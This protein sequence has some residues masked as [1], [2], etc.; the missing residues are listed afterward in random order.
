MQYASVVDTTNTAESEGM[1]LDNLFV[2]SPRS[3][4]SERAPNGEPN[5]QS[6]ARFTEFPV[7]ATIDLGGTVVVNQILAV[8]NAA[9]PLN[10]NNF[11][12]YASETQ[13]LN[14]FYDECENGH[15]FPPSDSDY[16]TENTRLGDQADC[17]GRVAR[18]ITIV[19][20]EADAGAEFFD[21]C[22]FGVM[23]YCDCYN[24]DIAFP[25]KN[26]QYPRDVEVQQGE[27]HHFVIKKPNY[28]FS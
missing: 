27:S 11:H 13:N 6:C 10:S 16:M 7:Q 9:H 12:V 3:Q 21:L 15:F 25:S 19:K 28:A 2:M 8:G 5:M 18:Y 20:E 1:G 14:Y 26:D 24:M 22:T 17:D 4:S 23:S